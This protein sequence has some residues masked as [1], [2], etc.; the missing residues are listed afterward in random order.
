MITKL[1]LAKLGF[2]E[3]SKENILNASFIL[4]KIYSI[5]GFTLRESDESNETSSVQYGDNCIAMIGNSINKVSQILFNDN[6]VEDEELWKKENKTSSPFLFIKY[7]PT[8]FHQLKGG[9]RQVNNEKIITYDGF[10]DARK[11]LKAWE[12]TNLYSI[13]TAISSQFSSVKQ[14][15]DILPVSR[16][17]LGETN[18]GVALEDIKIEV[19]ANASSSS[20]VKIDKLN[21]LLKA[22]SALYNKLDEKSSRSFYT[23]INEK[24]KLKQFLYFFFFI[25][26]YTHQTFKKIDFQ[27]LIDKSNNDS[28]ELSKSFLNSFLKLSKEAKNLTQR[29]HWCSILIWKLDDNDIESFQ[30]FKK[31]RDG[32]SHGEDFNEATL[33]VMDIR[34]LALKLLKC[35]HSL[36]EDKAFFTPFTKPMSP[37]WDREV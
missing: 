8:K 20:V 21:T 34:K 28:A 2:K 27:S 19:H 17:I 15:I 37:N 36:Y 4:V 35:E 32:I 24:D 14:I 25:E 13:I 33:P 1:G 31:T 6:F 29:F 26:R 9:Y 30:Y 3:Y 23:A 16:N 11:E 10:P 12:N 22:S 5:Q 18:E 7:G